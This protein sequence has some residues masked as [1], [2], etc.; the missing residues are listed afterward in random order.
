MK[1]TGSLVGVVVEFDLDLYKTKGGTPLL[2]VHLLM[3]LY[4]MLL[5]TIL[6]EKKFIIYLIEFG[7]EINP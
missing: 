2:Y 5:Y 7:F 3:A 6:F 1:I 4:S